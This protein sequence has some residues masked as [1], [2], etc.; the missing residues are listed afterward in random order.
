MI[1]FGITLAYWW[2]FE[3]LEHNYFVQWLLTRDMESKRKMT[4]TLG[5]TKKLFNSKTEISGT[6]LLTA[7][8]L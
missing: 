5:R 2:L 4:Y 6:D 3:L 7:L 8:L 1:V